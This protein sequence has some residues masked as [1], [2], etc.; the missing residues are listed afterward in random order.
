M[1]E[2]KGIKIDVTGSGEFTATTAGGLVVTATTLKALKR[3]L[4]GA[5][6]PF[7]ALHVTY[8]GTFAETR[9]IG[10]KVGRGYKNN[11]WE[12]ENGHTAEYVVADTP[13][14]RT[15]LNE[16]YEAE[17]EHA[18]KVSELHRILRAKRDAFDVRMAPIRHYAP[19]EK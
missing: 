13:E 14:N 6:E 1:L 10:V 7:K 3:K 18:D 15:L 17:R 8:A 16:I 19:S 9:V 2:Y 12:L 4:D 5:F 11:R